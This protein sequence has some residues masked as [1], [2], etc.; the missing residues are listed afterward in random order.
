MEVD[1][2]PDCPNLYVEGEIDMGLRE[3]CGVATKC[4]SDTVG[5]TWKVET[6]SG[7]FWQKESSLISQMLD[8]G[9]MDIGHIGSCD[10]GNG[11]VRAEIVGRVCN[12]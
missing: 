7:R 2:G 4:L 9:G 12:E 10:G 6:K 8:N 5:G 1:E 11:R 3:G